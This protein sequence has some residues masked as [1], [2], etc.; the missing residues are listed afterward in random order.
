[1]MDFGFHNRRIFLEDVLKE[2]PVP[3]SWYM[4]F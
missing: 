3:G 2:G 4:F 1:M